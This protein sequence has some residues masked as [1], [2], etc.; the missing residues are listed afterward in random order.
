MDIAL[1]AFAAALVA[2]VCQTATDIGTKASTRGCDDAT[3]LLA[4]WGL[5][6]ALVTAACLFVHPGLL[7]A[8]ATTLAALTKPGFWPLLF[9]DSAINIVAYLFYFR[10]F[11]LA[12]AS[13]VAPLVLLTPL[14]MLVTSPL[15]L[16]ESVPP[17]GAIGVV[18]TV[19]GVGLLDAGE[20]PGR[21]LNFVT[22]LRNPGA[23]AMLTTAA[24]WSIAANIDRMGV[25]ASTPLIWITGVTDA[26]ALFA[27]CYR[28]S[29][30]HRPAGLRA[31]R[32]AFLAGAAMS[33]GNTAQMWALTILF[34][35]YV[36]AIKRLSALFTVLA[37]GRL[38]KEDVGGRLPGAALMLAGAIIIALARR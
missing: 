4:Q 35:P 6:A 22:F 13:L 30:P 31:L 38:L 12:D 28:L 17:A 34:A 37:S 16:G 15:M 36:I 33:V 25:L 9:W 8:P 19:V 1:L 20:K 14:L 10:A 23:R 32:P 24:L 5:S 18:F 29:R 2:A 27:L 11:R 7:G 26:I 21:R 3:S